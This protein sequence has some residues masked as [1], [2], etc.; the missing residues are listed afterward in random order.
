MDKDLI[1]H[2]GK[3]VRCFRREDKMSIEQLAKL[4]GITANQLEDLEQEPLWEDQ[5]LRTASRVLDVPFG[6]LE[7][8]YP[9]I[10]EKQAPITINNN[11]FNDESSMSKGEGSQ[12]AG[13]INN[14]EINITTLDKIVDLYHDQVADLKETIAALR[15]EIKDLKNQ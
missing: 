9:D 3:A 11:T 12:V 1:A 2:H 15:K 6:L 13:G 8:Y 5:V 10:F 4:M 14:G 7:M